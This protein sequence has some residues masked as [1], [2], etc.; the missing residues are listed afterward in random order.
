VSLWGRVL[1]IHKSDVVWSY[2]RD[3]VTYAVSVW[4]EREL[5]HG[6]GFDWKECCMEVISSFTTLTDGSLPIPTY[7]R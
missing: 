6:F 3:G 5:I 4:D 7:R 2:I 1:F